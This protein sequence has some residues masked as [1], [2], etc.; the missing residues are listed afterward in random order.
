MKTGSR[1]RLDISCRYLQEI[2]GSLT[3]RQVNA[4]SD[5][6]P[7]D[8]QQLEQEIRDIETEFPGIL[9]R[10][11]KPR[12]FQRRYREYTYPIAP[13]LAYLNRALPRLEAELRGEDCEVAIEPLRFDFLANPELAALIQRDYMEL[14]EIHQAQCWKAAIILAGGIIEAILM[15][16]IQQDNGTS[17]AKEGSHSAV[18]KW[19]LSKLI[20]VSV[21]RGL[22]SSAIEKLSHAV[23]EYRNIVHPGNEIRKSLKFGPEEANIALEVIHIL[24]RELASSTLSPKPDVSRNP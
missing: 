18:D 7:D 12:A 22:V 1:R 21:E 24:H 9:P 4:S 23:R 15:A 11:Q 16:A 5:I 3:S 19:P 13:L 6:P 2:R 10:F 14:R 8:Y 20:K 17:S